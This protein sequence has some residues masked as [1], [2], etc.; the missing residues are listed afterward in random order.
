VEEIYG[1]PI[2]LSTGRV[3]PFRLIGEQHVMEDLER[4]PMVY[5]QLEKIRPEPWM[6]A[7][8]KQALEPAL[9]IPTCESPT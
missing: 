2:T 8:C 3:R 1:S 6:L 9:S 4:T 5:E 7:R